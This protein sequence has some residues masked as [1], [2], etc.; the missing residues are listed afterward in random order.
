[1]VTQTFVDPGHMTKMATMPIYGKTLKIF[2]FGTIVRMS[3]ILSIGHS[4]TAKMILGCSFSFLCKGQLCFLMHSFVCENAS[5]VD[6]SE[7]IEVCDIKVAIY[8]IV[9]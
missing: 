2:F 9:N 5:V 7:S 1:M 3:L 8:S 4:S 6:Y